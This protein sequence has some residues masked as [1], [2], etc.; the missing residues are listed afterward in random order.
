VGNVTTV[1][2]PLGY[3]NGTATAIQATDRLFT[4]T[5][6]GGTIDSSAAYAIQFT[7]TGSDVSSGT[8][9]RTL[10]LTG[11]QVASTTYGTSSIASILADASTGNTLA[12][13][14]TGAGTWALN[15]ANTYTGG[16]TVTGGAL[17]INNTTGSGTGT[18]AVTVQNGGTFGGGATTGVTAKTY[19]ASS[20]GPYQATRT[21]YTAG[22]NGI[23]TGAVEVQSGGILQPGDA[24]A[25]GTLTLGT[26][27]L[28][29]GS[30]LV[31]DFNS[32]SNSLVAVTAS[33]GLTLASGTGVITL[34]VFAAGTTNPYNTIGVYNIFSYAGS[35][36][37]GNLTALTANLSPGTYTFANDTADSVIQLDITSAPEP[38]VWAMLL[39]GLGLLVAIR[40]ARSRS[41]VN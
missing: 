10:T 35:T 33:G 18:G 2:N 40:R 3:A 6:N 27:T 39:G 4:V 14:K 1:A 41:S 31:Y 9:N 15:G 34:D 38:K 17:L 23:S 20:P 13:S 25:V 32:T 22:K 37:N 26:L 30:A 5:A 29:A 28:D 24:G 12:V 11:S 16:T 19:G 8:G 7:N 21:N 36:F